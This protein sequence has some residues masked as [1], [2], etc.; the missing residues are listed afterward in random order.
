MTKLNQIY[1]EIKN[2][3]AINI[4]D[5][6]MKDLDAATIEIDKNY[7]IF[8]DYS[9]LTN[10]HEEFMRVAHELGHC[11]TGSTHFMNSPLEIIEKHEYKA[12]KWIVNKLLPL[13]EIKKAGK[14]GITEISDLAEYFDLP[15]EFIRLSYYIYKMSGKVS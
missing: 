10:Q 3:K 14:K 6:K 12:N 15:E 5:Y 4:Y 13:E 11:K 2:D 1:D 8:V 9:K 7:G